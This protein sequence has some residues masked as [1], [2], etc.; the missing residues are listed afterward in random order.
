MNWDLSVC[1]EQEWQE[2][3]PTSKNTNT[4]IYLKKNQ[5][6][7]IQHRIL[8]QITNPH[9]FHKVHNWITNQPYNTEFSSKSNP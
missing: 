6:T 1:L 5:Q 3:K 2:H 8:Q 4:E 9:D 7:T